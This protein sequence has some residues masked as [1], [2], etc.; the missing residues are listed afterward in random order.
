MISHINSLLS[1]DSIFET[2]HQ[3]NAN[4]NNKPINDFVREN[5]KQLRAAF[6]E[7]KNFLLHEINDD[8]YSNNDNRSVLDDKD[9]ENLSKI[10]TA[11]NESQINYE[12]SYTIFEIEDDKITVKTR[13]NKSTPKSDSGVFLQYQIKI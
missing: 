7:N 2:L 3:L 13:F 6:D 12:D 9:S 5:A 10:E 11:N 4:L 8:N 1:S